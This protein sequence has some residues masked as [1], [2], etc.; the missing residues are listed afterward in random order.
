[1][2]HKFMQHQ[3]TEGHFAF[4]PLFLCSKLHQESFLRFSCVAI[5]YKNTRVESKNSSRNR[6]I[7]WPIAR[8]CK[9]LHIPGQHFSFPSFQSIGITVSCIVREFS[10]LQ[11]LHE[12]NNPVSHFSWLWHLAW[13]SILK[14]IVS[15]NIDLQLNLFTIVLSHC[16]SFGMNICGVICWWLL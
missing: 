8:I 2:L 9:C 13:S 6:Y 4:V 7:L 16:I 3:H 10:C 14:L 5:E 11:I 1:M 12:W 15:F